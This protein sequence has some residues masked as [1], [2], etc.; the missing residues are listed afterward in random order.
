MTSIIFSMEFIIVC[1]KFMSF[2]MKFIIVCMKSMSFSMELIIMGL[3][4]TEFGLCRQSSCWF[5]AKT[6]ESLITHNL[7]F[8]GPRA[9]ININD[10]FGAVSISFL[11]FSVVFSFEWGKTI[12][13]KA[14]KLQAE[15]RR[16]CRMVCG[17]AA[18]NPATTASSTP[19]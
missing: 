10:G 13:F 9:M 14:E 18:G 19:G 11:F 4:W 8:N 15:A 5:Q 6:Q 17:T 16:S 7:F 1:I 12:F 3:V 2:S